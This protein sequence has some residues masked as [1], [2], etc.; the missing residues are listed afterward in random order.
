MK[1][2]PRDL[3]YTKLRYL[4]ENSAT[5]RLLKS[6]TF[7]FVAS[8]LFISFRKR[9]RQNVPEITLRT[10]LETYIEGLAKY[11][12]R[13]YES[14]PK[15]YLDSWI[16]NGYIRRYY[17]AGQEDASIEATFETEKTLDFLLS[18]EQQGFVGTESRLVL[19]LETIK[20]LAIETDSNPTSRLSELG[21]KRDEIDQEI[22]LIELNGSASVLTDTQVKE[23]FSFFMEELEKLPTDFRKVTD[24]FRDI[25]TNIKSNIIEENKGRHFILNE[26]R[27]YNSS[28]ENSDQGKSFNGFMNFLRSEETRVTADEHLQKVMALPVVELMLKERYGLSRASVRRIWTGL[29]TPAH[30]VLE[31][32]AHFGEQIRRIVSSSKAQET[33]AITNLINDLKS[34][35]LKSKIKLRSTE[36]FFHFNRGLNIFL[37]QEKPLWSPQKTEHF[38]SHPKENDTFILSDEQ[39]G[40]IF[41]REPI[42][43]EQLRSNI[44]F[45]LER[46]TQVTL[47]EVIK[48]NPIKNGLRELM[49][50]I[51]LAHSGE[52]IEISHEKYDYCNISV[53]RANEK[54]EYVLKLPQIIFSGE[55]CWSNA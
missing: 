31:A 3:S 37:P 19:I 43:L 52:G 18:L 6:D 23:Y 46:K 53:R 13:T 11:N 28:L 16:A 2:T 14:T 48:V 15:H 45:A 35:F 47:G 9:D 36:H 12:E 24:N 54:I 51:S 30:R 4:S 39:I 1:T 50:Y 38:T 5:I 21:R 44:Y 27:N 22:K 41:S 42:D 55:V 34:S 20:K 32:K 8:F 10:E 25:T 29:Y 49:G 7:A 40:S 26:A 17:V 33:K